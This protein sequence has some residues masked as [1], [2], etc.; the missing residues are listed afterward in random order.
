MI[1]IFSDM[2]WLDVLPI[3]FGIVIFRRRRMGVGGGRSPASTPEV[4]IQY[5]DGKFLR[6]LDGTTAKF[7]G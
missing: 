6:F 5:L 7:L 1:D 3:M 4:E 2:G